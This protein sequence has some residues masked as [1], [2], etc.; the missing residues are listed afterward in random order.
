[1]KWYDYI[2]NEKK[3]A[4][5]SLGIALTIALLLTSWLAVQRGIL[6]EAKAQK[7]QEKLAGEVLRFHVLAN[8][9]SDRDQEV[10]M[11]VKEAVL[12]YM[13]QELPKGSD[14]DA[15]R[16]WAKEHLNEIEDIS[17][18]T[19]REAGSDDPVTA[20]ITRDDFPEKTYGDITFPA[21]E[22]EALR[23][24]I[25]EAK[26]HNWWCCLYPNLCFTDAVHAVVPDEGKEELKTVLDEEEYEMVTSTTN[27]KIKWYFFGD[28]SE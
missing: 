27:F 20:E 19:L 24:K 21:G 26:G 14:I 28:R 3:R 1:M 7:A 2:K 13:K 11:Q 6:V 10:K 12:D 4:R 5:I 17:G 15:T 25:G 9:D 18:K 23:I 8:S 22:Y 16:E